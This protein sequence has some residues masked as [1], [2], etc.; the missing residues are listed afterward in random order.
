MIRFHEGRVLEY[1]SHLYSYGLQGDI[2]CGHS[3]VPLIAHASSVTCVMWG[4]TES[5]WHAGYELG[6]L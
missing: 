2:G 1:S 3:T 5:L 6:P 4:E